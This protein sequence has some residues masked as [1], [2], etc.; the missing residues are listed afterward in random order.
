MCGV[1]LEFVGVRIVF[2]KASRS[3]SFAFTLTFSAG[4]VA[5]NS[6][7]PPSVKSG[8]GVWRDDSESIKL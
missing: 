6:F 8:S 5:V 3:S 4:S 1:V 7:V 2:R